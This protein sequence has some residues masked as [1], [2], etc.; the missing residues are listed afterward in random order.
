RSISSPPTTRSDRRTLR[1]AAS[2]TDSGPRREA[3]AATRRR[4]RARHPSRSLRNRPT[5]R[6]E[7]HDREYRDRDQPP[8]REAERAEVHDAGG[9]LTPK[10]QAGHQ[11]DQADQQQRQRDAHDREHQRTPALVDRRTGEA[12]DEEEQR[13][14]EVHDARSDRTGLPQPRQVEDVAV[15]SPPVREQFDAGADEE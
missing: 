8:E 4:R 6:E 7:R 3:P 12:D 15:H 2:A 13:E 11:V 9:D 10:L 5:E 14:R 1:A